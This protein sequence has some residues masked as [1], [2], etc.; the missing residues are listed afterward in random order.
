[1]RIGKNLNL[2]TKLTSY[3]QGIALH[4]AYELAYLVSGVEAAELEHFFAASGYLPR[5]TLGG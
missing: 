1:M 5:L 2:L 4:L 3:P